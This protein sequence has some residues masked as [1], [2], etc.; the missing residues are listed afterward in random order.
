MINLS[1][2][3]D[4]VENKRLEKPE[5]FIKRFLSKSEID[6]YNK[7]VNQE[8]KVEFLSGRWAAK[9]SIIKALDKKVSARNIEIINLAS[10]KPVVKINGKFIEDIEISISHERNYSIAFC[11]LDKKILEII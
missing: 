6:F 8:S 11:V 3:T 7:I 10:G 9:E 4:I 1:I 5:G 2:G